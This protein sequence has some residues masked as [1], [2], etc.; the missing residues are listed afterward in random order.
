[1]SF[2]RYPAYKDSGVEWLG[3]VPAHWDV[4]PLKR[5]FEVT[6][7]KMV[8]REGDEDER[9]IFPYL[10]SANVQ[11]GRVAL[12][13]VKRMWLSPDE[14]EALSLREG[15]LLICEG[16]DVG[17][18]AVLDRDLEGFGFQNSVL[19]VRPRH[20]AENRV[21]AY[22]L[23]L[24]KEHGFIDVVCNKATIAHFTADKVN[25]LPVAIAPE[26]EQGLIAEF[27][28][29][30]T[31]KIDGLVRE[32][33]ALLKLL[34]EKRAATIAHVVTKGLDPNVPMK[35]SGV[36]WLGQV[37]AH[38]KAV[39]LKHVG[40]IQGGAGFPDEYQHNPDERLPFY[41]VAN[42]GMSLDGRSI[43]PSVHTVSDETAA[44]LRASIIPAGSIVYAKIGAAM[45][46]NR[47]R[48]VEHDC[49]IDNNMTALTVDATKANAAWVFL[50]MQILDFKRLTNP[51]PVPSFSEGA[52]RDLPIL[53][54]PDC[55]QEEIVGHVEGATAKLDTLAAEAR[56]NI[57][58][59]RERRAALISTA[60]TGRIDVRDTATPSTE[61]GKAA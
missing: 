41:K 53:L 19:R 7:G 34:E 32:Q 46:L 40:K 31:G 59:L 51:G 17:R 49:C 44:T 45:L 25:S 18:C 6:L 23:T 43:G 24:L 27:L 4:L 58:L 28:D 5:R 1:M 14:R 15:D 26:P 29:R 48:L 3:P 21:L 42:L 36:E 8:T 9:E 54:P 2:P 13:D 50:W 52:Q 37:P 12:D 10:R 11:A 22:W 33:E 35:D 16:G 20:A 55:D 47:R 38:W 57:S 39:R 56:K 61:V 60:V 30:E